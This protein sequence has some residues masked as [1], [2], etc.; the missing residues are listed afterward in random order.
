[1][2]CV[3]QKAISQVMCHRN[4]RIDD[5][6]ALKIKD[7]GKWYVNQN[8]SNCVFTQLMCADEVDNSLICP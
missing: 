7:G 3:V 1:M 5:G 4:G 8:D 2:T 6:S